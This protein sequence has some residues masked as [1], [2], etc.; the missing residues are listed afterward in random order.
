MKQTVVVV[1]LFA[2]DIFYSEYGIMEVLMQG[3][4]PLQMSYTKIDNLSIKQF[5]RNLI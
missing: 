4:L 5:G 3:R 2:V 1:Q